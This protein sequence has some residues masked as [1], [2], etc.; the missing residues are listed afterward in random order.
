MDKEK[1]EQ[2]L[3]D[4]NNNEELKQKYREAATAEEKAAVFA[5]AT[6]LA[7]G[8]KQELSDE[9]LDSVN[10]GSQHHYRCMAVCS[11]F[12]WRSSVGSPNFAYDLGLE[13]IDNSQRCMS[14]NV[15]GL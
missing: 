14:F 1:M 8:G 3:H 4:L 12:G 15:V 2:V 6:D 7:S 10:G 9:D 11:Q 13:H 5:A